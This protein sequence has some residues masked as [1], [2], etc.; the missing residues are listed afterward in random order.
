MSD[1]AGT[2]NGWRYSRI[3]KASARGSPMKASRSGAGWSSAPRVSFVCSKS[4]SFSRRCIDD[5]LEGSP[6]S[7]MHL[8]FFQR[9]L[10]FR[11]RIR[12]PQA[13]GDVADVTQ[14]RRL[15]ACHDVG[16]EVGPVPAANRLEEICEV[17]LAV[18]AEGTDQFAVGIEQRSTR[19]K[20]LAPFENPPVL[21][22]VGRSLQRSE[23]RRVGKECRSR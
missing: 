21:E 19:D 4:T 2:T 23:E 13:P 20:P 6:R 8:E 9:F 14:L 16:V 15:M 3:R 11:R 22:A 7:F 1:S 18:A 12:M 5:A 17:T 10:D